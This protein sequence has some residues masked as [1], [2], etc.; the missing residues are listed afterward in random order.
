MIVFCVFLLSKTTFPG[1]P[2][3]RT[4]QISGYFRVPVSALSNA[5]AFGTVILSFV[6]KDRIQMENDTLLKVHNLSHDI[7]GAG[8]LHAVS[9]SLPSGSLTVM[10]GRNGSG[11]SML[12][13]AIKG[14]VQPREGTILLEDTDL[15]SSPSR[16]NQSIGLVFQDADTQIVGQTVKRDIMF[17]LENLRLDDE[18]KNRRFADV[19]ALMELEEKLDRR[20]RTLSGGEKRRLAIAGILAMKP[21][22]LMLDEPF[23]NLDYPGIRHVL[24][25]LL[26]LREAGHTLF[27]V[28]HDCD[29][30]LF[31]ADRVL[32]LEKG[33]IIMDRAPV[34]ALDD[35]LLHDV[36]IPTYGGRPVPLEELTCLKG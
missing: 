21:R 16:R 20:P 12:L 28:T 29:K 33:S 23:A 36:H 15:S 5:A 35:L 14:L 7:S 30:I 1:I 18:E 34:D 9:F 10:T 24:T 13:R 25:A 22:L 3:C 19:V 11:K 17:G 4:R 8:I 32:L 2:V 26:A 6:K 31:H 27:V